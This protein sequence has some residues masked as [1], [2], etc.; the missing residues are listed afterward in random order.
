MTPREVVRRTIRFDHPERMAVDFFGEYARQLG[1]STDFEHLCME[2][3]PDIK[4]LGGVDEWGAVWHSSGSAV[5]LGEVKEFPLADWSQWANLRVP[6]VRDPVRWQGVHGVRGRVGE[7]F[8]IGYGI[9]MYDRVHFLRGLENTWADIHENPDKL[10]RLLDVIAELNIQSM[11]MYAAAGADAIMWFDDWGL[12][13][14]LMISPAAFRELWKPRY[15]RLYGRAHELGLLTFLHSCGYIV[16]ILDDLIE[17]GL[18]VIQ[19]DQQENMGLELL[20]ERFAGRITFYCPV[21]IQK[22]MIA[23]SLDD[24]RAYARRLVRTFGRYNGGFI[25]KWY[26][27]PAAVQHTQERVAAMCE[28]FVAA[29]AEMAVV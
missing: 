6:N 2:P 27:S 3:H 8:I 12:Q 22:T 14:R 5:T 19:M 9:S 17:T 25:S 13:D 11:E 28:A 16:E 18:D 15:T 24:I 23:G 26:P 21:D 20:G 7:K 4:P 10:G 1:S 29:G